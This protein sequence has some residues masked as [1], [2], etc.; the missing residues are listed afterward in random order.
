[1]TDTTETSPVYRTSQIA[2]AVGV[3]PNT[4]RLYERL[5]FISPPERRSNRYRVFT[6]RHVEQMLLARA[7]LRTAVLQADLRRQAFAIIAAVGEGDLDH[8][9]ELTQGYLQTVGSEQRR[10]TEALGIVRQLLAREPIPTN[11]ILLKRQQ[12]ADHLGVTI[13]TLRN[14]ERNNLITVERGP[15]GYRVYTD[16]VIRRAKIVRTLR[17]AHFSL[18][19]VLRLMNQL[20]RDPDTNLAA[21]IDQ[22]RPDD[23][24]VSVC[25][26]LLTSLDQAAANADEVLA[27]IGQLRV[28]P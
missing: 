14:W 28:L 10:V 20:D 7:I 21:V 24:I 17:L 12:A 1:M 13:E 19:A 8:A 18:S 6:R 22:P 3:H 15:N 25:D 16:E 4:V 27:R 11:Q 9:E 2:A 23:D 26:Q 5:G